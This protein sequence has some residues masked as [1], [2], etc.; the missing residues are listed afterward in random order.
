MRRVERHAGDHLVPATQVLLASRL[1]KPY[2]MKQP[3]R[4]E[5]GTISPGLAARDFSIVL[6]KLE[7]LG[8]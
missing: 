8:P 5:N 7:D 4:G 3:R 1:F 6:I 2:G